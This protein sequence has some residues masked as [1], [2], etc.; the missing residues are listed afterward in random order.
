MHARLAVLTALAVAT[1]A[2]CADATAPSPAAVDDPP[3]A[4]ARNA[5][6]G[7]TTRADTARA[8]T[9]RADTTRPTRPDSARPTRPDSARPTRPDSARPPVDTL[10]VGDGV[11]AGVVFRT[12][13]F[14]VA[15]GDSAG[16][17]GVRLERIGGVALTL[18]AQEAAADS[19]RTP[20]PLR[21]VAR[22]TSA[23]DGAY[24]FA[25]VPDGLYRIR[26]AAPAGSGYRDAEVPV[27]MR[28]GRPMVLGAPD[29][30]VVLRN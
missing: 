29:I 21:E 26:A 7:R 14:T 11:I 3:A 6:S 23:A 22:T 4:A 9:A 12:V 5:D 25:P 24:R 30:L 20:P 18:Y 27:A 10:P 8:D 17:R 16:M 2:A 28:R 1:L 19:S 13:E 15:A